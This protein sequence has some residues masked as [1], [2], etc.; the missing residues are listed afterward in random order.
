MVQVVATNLPPVPSAQTLDDKGGMVTQQ[1]QQWFV[2]L[3]DKVNQINAVVVAI[4]GAGTPIATFNLLSPLTTEGDMLTYH[5]GNNIRLP[6]G[7]TGQ[8]LSVVGGLPAWVNPSAGSSPLT[9]KGDVYGYDTAPN[10][11][12]VGT[13]GYVL[14][15]DSTLALGVGWKPAGTPTLPL[16]TKGDLLGY[17]TAPDRVPIGI[18][19]Q[20]LT[21]DS[22][23]TLGLKWAAAGTASPLTTKGDLY[24]FSTVNT[25]IPVG[26]DGQALTADSTTAAG[27]SYKSTTPLTTKGDIVVYGSVVSRL[28][29]GA[30]GQVLISDSTQSLGLRWGAVTSF[31]EIFNYVATLSNNGF[32]NYTIRIAIPG[33]LL[34]NGS[35]IRIKLTT[36]PATSTTTAITAC[37]IGNAATSSQG[38]NIDFSGSPTQITFGG[39][40]N[41]SITGG[42]SATSD[43]ITFTTAE[44]TNIVVTFQMT[45]GDAYA[46]NTADTNVKAYAK[47]VNN[48][49]STTTTS[50]YSASSNS[51]IF[52]KCL[53][54]IPA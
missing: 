4:S 11:I 26:T 2:N 43:V 21:A 49:A 34:F 42:K 54:I 38:F 18:D 14:T 22:T 9:T 53:Q 35:A 23:Q 41:I 15:A 6:I 28:P 5:S 12:P 44:N 8:I 25:R 10:R 13:N 20:V 40:N 31:L 3:R 48:D 37:Y 19:G 17:D 24:G 33:Y 1:W 47:N 50:G 16:T 32:T 27:V 30:N 7:T 36:N 29:V 51:V 39:N 45:S 52:L 46:T